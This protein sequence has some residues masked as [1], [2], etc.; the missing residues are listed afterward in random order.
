MNQKGKKKHILGVALT[1]AVILVLILSGPVSAIS[2]N[3]SLDD[4]SVTAG[5]AATGQITITTDQ[6]GERLPLTNNSGNFTLVVGSSGNCTYSMDGTELSGVTAICSALTVTE[7]TTTL[8]G[9][10]DYGYMW[11]YG[12]ASESASSVTNS[13]FGFGYGYGYTAGGNN[14]FTYNYSLATGSLTAGTYEMDVQVMTNGSSSSARFWST[15]STD[16][17]LTVAAAAASS[18]SSSSSGGTSPQTGVSTFTA[19]IAS[20]SEGSQAKF[21]FNARSTVNNIMFTAGSTLSNAKVEVS[22]VSVAD[23]QNALNT[24]LSGKV[25][26]YMTIDPKKFSNDDIDGTATVNFKVPSS[27]LSANGLG[28]DNVALFR[29]A[30]GTWTE[31]ET[32]YVNGDGTNEYFTAVTPGFSYFAIGERGSQPV[33]VVAE[34]GEVAGEAA[35]EGE[36]EEAAGP[37]STGVIVAIIVIVLILLVAYFAFARKRRY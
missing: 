29:Y 24:V 2:V 17:S 23:V 10:Y 32:S 5:T 1:L 18:S 6:T 28:T 14:V 12:Y 25:Y 13:T 35:E 21:N 27:W 15:D 4:A 16:T 26:K 31:L 3:V 33:A 22:D 11:G 36:P 37:S 30:G 20:V 9:Q 8:V 19:T 34:E 7:V